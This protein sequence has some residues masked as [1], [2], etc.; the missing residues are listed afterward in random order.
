MSTTAALTALAV[1]AGDPSTAPLATLLARVDR[2]WAERDA[3]GKLGEITAALDEATRMA[4]D[5]FE[6]LWRVARLDVWRADDPKLPASERSKIGKRA[7]E[8]ADRA[9]AKEP[10]RVEGHL[11]AAL[12]MGNYALALG[13]IQ[14]LR[15]GIEGKFKERLSR[16]EQIDPRFLDGTVY[17]AWG[18]FW[19]ELPWPKYSA[20]RSEEALRRAFA[21]NPANERARVF[22]AE[23]YQK[24][25]RRPE[26]T[27]LLREAASAKPGA[28]DAPEERRM[29]A[30]ARELLAKDRNG[31]EHDRSAGSGGSG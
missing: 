28:Y 31:D 11:Y 5:A 19:Y 18:R 30:R 22:L 3:P 14:A 29:Q 10:G 25:G 15:Q 9:A 6:V 16:A 1:L 23:L 4:P 24:E 8:L 27:A 13:V 7:W 20:K 2:D 17:V 21:V 12:G 26:A